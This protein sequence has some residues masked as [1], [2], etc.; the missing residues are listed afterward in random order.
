[1]CAASGCWVWQ[2]LTSG[3]LRLKCPAHRNLLAATCSTASPAACHVSHCIRIWPHSPSCPRLHAQNHSVPSALSCGLFFG[4]IGQRCSSVRARESAAAFAALN[5]TNA[6]NP[7]SPS[8]AAAVAA[9]AANGLPALVNVTGLEALVFGNSSLTAD[10]PGCTTSLDCFCQ[11]GT[12]QGLRP[13]PFAFSS[14][15]S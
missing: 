1:M 10:S 7:G 4:A 14:N 6:D 13:A 5:V 15:G 9:G 12:A 3:R 2:Q 8:A 11:V